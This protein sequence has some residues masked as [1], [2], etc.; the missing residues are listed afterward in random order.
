M[1]FP[2]SRI[3]ARGRRGCLP[4][5][6]DARSGAGLRDPGSVGSLDREP[7]RG[8]PYPRIVSGSIAVPSVCTVA[9]KTNP[10]RAL[11]ITFAL[12]LAVV[13]QIALPAAPG[14]REL[15]GPHE[16][17]R[18]EPVTRRSFLRVGAASLGGVAA[19]SAGQRTPKVS[20]FIELLR[21]PDSV[22]AYGS[23]A[24]TLPA[25]RIALRPAG[26]QWRGGSC[27]ECAAQQDALVLTL[28][29]PSTPI[30]AVHVRWRAQV[31]P[32]LRA[33]GDAWERSYGELGWRD[34]IP[35]RVMPWYFATY[36]GP[37][38]MVTE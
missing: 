36:D 6:T 16:N 26:V 18:S 23:F 35:E 29:A 2:V 38:A 3:F 7:N 4:A 37:P 13:R 31:S 14:D 25:G 5:S 15:Y 17:V 12:H 32:G 27:G 24:R 33:L 30:A 21:A 19:G 11:I 1:S 20:S 22:T 10:R 8:A 34:L 9:T 28:A